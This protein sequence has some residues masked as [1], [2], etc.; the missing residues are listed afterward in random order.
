ME[1]F[2]NKLRNSENLTFNET[3]EVFEI[4]M[5]GNASDKEIYDFLL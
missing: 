1:K 4:L 5:T 3:K 2:L